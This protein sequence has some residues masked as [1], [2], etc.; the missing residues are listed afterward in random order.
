MRATYLCRVLLD[1]IVFTVLR[2]DYWR[3]SSLLCKCAIVSYAIFVKPEYSSHFALAHP[4]DVL[5]IE[6]SSF[7]PM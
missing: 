2:Y 7:L 6:R 3:S 1:L 5:H 4:V